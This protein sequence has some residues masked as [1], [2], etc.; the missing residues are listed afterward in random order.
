LSEAR[1]IIAKVQDDRTIASFD[2]QLND[3]G[4]DTALSAGYEIGIA[5]TEILKSSGPWLPPDII[6]GF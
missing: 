3:P 5:H 1:V 4:A 2:Q 6:I